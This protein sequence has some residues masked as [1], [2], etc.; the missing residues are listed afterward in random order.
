MLRRSD[1]GIVQA[2]LPAVEVHLV[3]PQVDVGVGEHGADLLEE[4]AHEVIGGVQDGVHWAEG[5]RGFGAR[6][7]RGEKVFLP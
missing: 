1:V 2:V 3:P 7:T 4:L 5:A 6:V